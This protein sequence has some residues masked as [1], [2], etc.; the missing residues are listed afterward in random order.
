MF[1]PL[2]NY[3]CFHEACDF[4][5]CKTIEESALFKNKEI[6]LSCTAVTI[7]DVECV[8]VFL[9]SSFHKDW[10]KVDLSPCYIQ[11]HGLYIYFTMD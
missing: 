7:S 2:Y 4:D 1:S 11:D 3:H 10:V 8:T 9:A 5:I 6:D